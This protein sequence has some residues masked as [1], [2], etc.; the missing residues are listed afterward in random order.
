MN[1]EVEIANLVSEA[2]DVA[3]ITGET[4]P[5][6]LA[7]I[8]LDHIHWAYLRRSPA[9]GFTRPITRPDALLTS[10]GK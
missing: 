6:I 9:G 8:L 1:R 10:G 5:R 3:E 7:S 4:V 2:E